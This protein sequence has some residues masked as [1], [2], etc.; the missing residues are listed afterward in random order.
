[1]PDRSPPATQ[2]ALSRAF[3]S[4]AGSLLIRAARSLADSLRQAGNKLFLRD[5]AF[6][7]AHG[8]QIQARHGGLSRTYR[9]PRFAQLKQGLEHGQQEQQISRA[10][11]QPRQLG[12]HLPAPPARGAR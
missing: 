1:M 12:R 11:G 7:R 9:D 3:H 8:W 10:S 5:D 2:P 6:A 4:H